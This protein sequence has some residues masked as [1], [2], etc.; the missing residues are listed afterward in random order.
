[1]NMKYLLSLLLLFSLNVYSQ[2]IV[3]LKHK[4]YTA[5]YSKSK[6][7]PVRVEWWLT[8]SMLECPTK[9]KRS[10]NFTADPLLPAETNL[11]KDYD[12]SGFDRG[13]N[14]NAAD[15]ACDNVSMNESFYF[16]NMTAQYPSL[17]RGDWKTLESLTR[18]WAV[19]HDSI[20]VWCGSVGEI[21][22]I[23]ST[24]IPEKCWKAI[25]IK[26]TKEWKFF[27]FNNDTSKA[28]GIEN[29]QVDK[30]LIQILTGLKFA[31]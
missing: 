23:G 14:F 9:V 2:D 28:D 18:E 29:N 16:S 22:K 13:H 17:N 1:M 11:Q 3:E 8:K 5:F 12:K 6:H 21:K 4:S 7:Y 19:K 25:Y 27:L 31:N 24:S 20:K 30:S 26:K 10:D 15:G